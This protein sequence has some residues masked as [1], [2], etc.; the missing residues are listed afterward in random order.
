MKKSVRLTLNYFTTSILTFKIGY[1]HIE[2]GQ[3]QE[4]TFLRLVIYYVV[5]RD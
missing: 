5:A 1:L 3:S 2:A 4:C